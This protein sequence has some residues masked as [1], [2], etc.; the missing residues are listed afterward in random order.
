MLKTKNLSLCIL[1][2]YLTVFL[3]MGIYSLIKWEL[4][5]VDRLSVAMILFGLVWINRKVHFHPIIALFVGFIFIPHEAGI[6]YFYSSPILNWH[7]D[8][9]S[10]FVGFFF[11]SIVIMD[12]L[13]HNKY[14][15]KRVFVTCMITLSIAMS[16]GAIFEISEYW[17]FIFFGHGEGY[18]GFGDGDNSQNFGP[19]E[20]S[21]LDTSFNLLGSVL[22]VLIYG[23]ILQFTERFKYMLSYSYT[24]C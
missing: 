1:L 10:H 4:V 19:W 16:F 14:F 17:G 6:W 7:Y 23:G 8:W 13:L 11:C 21:S 9:I 24:L 5:A 2:A 18:L 3:I 20:N 12:I 22:A 15:S